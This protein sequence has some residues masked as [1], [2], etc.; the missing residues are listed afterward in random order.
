MNLKTIF[1]SAIALTVGVSSLHAGPRTS[2]AYQI[3]TDTL[4][5]AGRRTTSAS[6]T[7]DGS[8]GGIIGISSARFP[9]RR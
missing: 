8:A 9:P 4:D 2:T 7:N 3:I 1:L 5:V 6:Y